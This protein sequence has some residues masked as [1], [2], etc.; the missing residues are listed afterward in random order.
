MAACLGLACNYGLADFQ[1]KCRTFFLEN[2]GASMN[3]WVTANHP[4]RAILTKQLAEGMPAV[5]AELLL[6][7]IRR[8]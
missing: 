1:Q 6:D 3:H 4:Y 5:V 8:K 7:S 2:M